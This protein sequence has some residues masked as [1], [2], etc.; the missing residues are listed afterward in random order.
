MTLGDWLS[1]WMTLY[2]WPS[3]LAHNTK[4]CYDR[5][6][7]AVPQHLCSVDLMQ[8][9]PLR[10]RAW[11]L[12]V[13]AVHPRAAQLD[14]VMLCKALRIA[15][16][17]GEAPACLSDPE[18]LPQI[19]HKAAKAAVLDIAQLRTYM[20]TAAGDPHGVALML[21]ACGL[22]RGEALGARWE[23]LDIPA[24]TLA[25]VGQRLPGGAYAPP[26]TAASVRV[27][28]LPPT[29]TVVLRRHPRPIG[30]GW[31][32]DISP[33]ALY[34]AHRRVLAAASLPA[35]T[36]HGL[37][38]SFATAAVQQGVP[39]KVL[40]AALGHAKYQLTADLYADHLPDRSAVPRS[41][42]IA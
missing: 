37:R 16:K 2:V 7:R 5:S 12:D 15:A 13:A 26:K 31:L 27:L 35:I 33:S 20:Q 21:M 4:L 22:R 25:V 1:T 29:L 38:H 42:Y 3:D 39:I 23:N 28:E 10:L 8:L 14:R 9:S 6:V 30:G 32:C 18:L 17:A 41:V 34:N 40:Q 11:L 24:G 19:S 36:L